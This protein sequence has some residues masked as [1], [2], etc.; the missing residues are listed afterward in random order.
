[1]TASHMVASTKNANVIDNSDKSTT[2][3]SNVSN[4][5]GGGGDSNPVW[6]TTADS[7]ANKSLKGELAGAQ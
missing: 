5:N 7:T 2:A 6:I 3:I 4:V 1:M